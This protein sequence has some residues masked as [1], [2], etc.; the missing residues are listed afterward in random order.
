MSKTI[1]RKELS[2]LTQD[3]HSAISKNLPWVIQAMDAVFDKIELGEIMIEGYSKSYSKESVQSYRK[4]VK[5]E[6][7]TIFIQP[8]SNWKP[9]YSWNN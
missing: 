4:W 3:Y 6:S 8:E 1:T 2:T 7:G 9:K 5:S